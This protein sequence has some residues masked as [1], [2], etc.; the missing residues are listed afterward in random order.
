MAYNLINLYYLGE[1]VV[2]KTLIKIQL[3]YLSLAVAS[4]LHKNK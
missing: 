3:T 4:I 1:G 2:Q